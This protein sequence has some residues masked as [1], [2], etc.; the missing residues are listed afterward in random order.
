MV[1]RRIE[2]RSGLLLRLRAE[3]GP[4][5]GVVEDPLDRGAQRVVVVRLDEEPAHPVADGLRQRGRAVGDH[6][7]A[8]RHRLDRCVPEGVHHAR[9]DEHG[10]LGEQL[11]A[12]LGLVPGQVV[13]HLEAGLRRHRDRR[14]QAQAGVGC[15]AL[16]PDPQEA[17]PALALEGPS[18]PGDDGRVADGHVRSLTHE[19]AVRHDPDAIVVDAVVL[20]HGARRPLGLRDEQG[21]GVEDAALDPTLD[22]RDTVG[23]AGRLAER[24]E[25]RALGQRGI[26]AHDGGVVAQ[27]L[28]ERRADALRVEVDDRAR[29]EPADP[30][31]RHHRAGHVVAQ[32]VQVE[33]ALGQHG[34]RGP[35]G[36]VQ[37]AGGVDV[38]RAGV[39]L[40]VRFEG[41]PQVVVERPVTADV[42]VDEADPHQHLGASW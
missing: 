20:P 32:H 33:V 2:A 1:T 11:V 14:D 22:S 24:Q 18:R 40:G 16:P 6:R 28:G 7:S 12:S 42:L 39:D 29:L 23:V 10:R 37:A 27:Q 38:H 34:D 41:D 19:D 3:A 21:G 26:G 9:E 25:P 15:Q 36:A 30:S 13:D 31:P 17:G 8:H 4:Q 35:E 5:R